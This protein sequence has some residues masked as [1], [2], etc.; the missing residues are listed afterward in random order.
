MNK[1]ARKEKPKF[2][3]EVC[4]ACTM[5]VNICPTG[6]LDL[7][8]RNSTHGFRRYPVLTDA[9]KC[10]GCNACEQDCPSGAILMV[11]AT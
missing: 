4:I 7:E 8:I 11:P 5:C 3:R 9:K 2:D 1:N 6:A 10:I